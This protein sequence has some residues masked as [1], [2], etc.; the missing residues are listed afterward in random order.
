VVTG[1]DAALSARIV[2][3][4]LAITW[5][6]PQNGGAEITEGQIRIRTSDGATF[7]EEATQ[8]SLA[9]D[10]TEFDG[11][12][13]TIP[14]SALRSG[15]TPPNAYGLA[16]GDPIVLVIRFKNEVGWS[17]DSAEYAPAGL[18]MEAVP[19]VPTAAPYRVDANTHST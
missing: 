3:T 14:L 11:R 10:S 12:T 6:L 1:A 18:L 4:G 13:C 19:H 17:L 16:Q 7:T 9:E 2:G 8:C 5:A 15:E